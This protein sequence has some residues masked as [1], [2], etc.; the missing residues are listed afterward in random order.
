[1]PQIGNAQTGILK[2]TPKITRV[3]GDDSLKV[4]YRNMGNNHAHPF[5]WGTEL[6]VASGTTS[7]LASGTKLHGFGLANNANVQI[8]VSSGVQDGY[9]YVEKDKTNNIINIKSTCT[10]DVVVDVKFMLGVDYDI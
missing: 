7:L 9:V 1:M 5:I 6:T 8:T 10:T 4:I 3:N 2:S